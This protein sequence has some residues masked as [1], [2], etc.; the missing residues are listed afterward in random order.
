MGPKF[1]SN[2]NSVVFL[3]LDQIGP[4][5][6]MTHIASYVISALLYNAQLS[7]IHEVTDSLKPSRSRISTGSDD[8]STPTSSH[9]FHFVEHEETSS[10]VTETTNQPDTLTS[11]SQSDSEV[12]SAAQPTYLVTQISQE[13]NQSLKVSDDHFNNDGFSTTQV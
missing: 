5:I 11:E 7:V 3:L 1:Y 10:P 13:S 9:S 8:Q 6:V 12:Q 2:F 4:I